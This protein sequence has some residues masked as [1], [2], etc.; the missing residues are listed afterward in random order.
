M[1]G[2]HLRRVG[3][4]ET[5]TDT[6]GGF[7]LSGIPLESWDGDTIDLE[8]SGPEGDMRLSRLWVPPGSIL[9]P[10][11]EVTYMPGTT[12]NASSWLA[13]ISPLANSVG[14]AKPAFRTA[15]TSDRIYAT[16]EGLVGFTTANGHTIQVS[17]HFAA[18]P[19]R[20]A[21][22]RTDA[23]S[24]LEFEVE[25]VNGI[26]TIRLPVWD[27]GPWNTKD[28]WWNLDKFR[29]SIPDTAKGPL[30]QGTPEAQAAYLEGYNKGLVGSG[31]TVKNPAGIDLADGAFWED[32]A[33]TDNG[34]V[35]VRPLWRLDA[36]VGASVRARHWTKVRSTPGGAVVDTATCGQPGRLLAGPDSATV[37]GH[38]YLFYKVEWNGG[39]VG[40][41]AENFLAT[42]FL[43]T[44]SE[45]AL[46]V[47]R[48]P[49][50]RI[51][52]HILLL[53]PR[54]PDPIE[55]V[56]VDATGRI[57]GRSGPL[58]GASG[59]R[60]PNSMGI[61]FIEVRSGALRQILTRSP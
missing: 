34:Y 39:S 51:S 30:L 55:I 1:P 11:L 2:A 38:W 20:R 8:V 25:V 36:E 24:D 10:R 15:A 29:Q 4:A 40:W 32:L 58:R 18:L 61:Q 53:A 27:V 7:L 41:S 49:L 16:R 13:S 48:E 22:N 44:C 28:D 3:G 17:D 57:L 19:S 23:P 31:R 26:N 33:L 54:G 6:A 50:A 60:L 43:A 5:S 46:P 52:G 59:W 45:A 9:A 35:Q 42:D 12:S 14:E 56:V 21:L 47:N 37:S